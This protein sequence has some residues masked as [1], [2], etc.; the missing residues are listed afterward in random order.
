[1]NKLT[2][3]LKRNVADITEIYTGGEEMSRCTRRNI[4][5]V[6]LEVRQD[7][8]VIFVK[9]GNRNILIDENASDGDVKK[10][11][12]FAREHGIPNTHPPKP[13]GETS[14]W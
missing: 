7:A 5:G 6:C 10:A 9:A 14:P 11:E 2:E 8:S 3:A 12:K 1:M 4:H 13:F